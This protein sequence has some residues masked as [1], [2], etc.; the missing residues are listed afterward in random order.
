MTQIEIDN[1][2]E[3]LTPIFKAAQAKLMDYL[4][5]QQGNTG[6]FSLD[7]KKQRKIFYEEKQAYNNT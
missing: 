2:A 7:E 5:H 1:D 6:A 4:S 3:K